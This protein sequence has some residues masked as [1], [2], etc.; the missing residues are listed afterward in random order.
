MDDDRDGHVEIQETKEFMA[1]ELQYKTSTQEKEEKFHGTDTDI[2]V[3]ELWKA[4][5]YSEVYNWTTDNLVVWINDH[6][7]LPQYADY[8]RRNRIDGQFLPR[9][10]LNENNYY[11]NVMQIKD[12]RHKRL[13]MIKATDLVLFGYHQ[14]TLV[15]FSFVWLVIYK[16]YLLI[17]FKILFK[18]PHNLIKDVLMISSLTLSIFVCIYLYSKHRQSLEQIKQMINDFEKLAEL[19]VINKLHSSQQLQNQ[20]NNDSWDLSSNLFQK[21]NST[22]EIFN[23]NFL[24]S[25][26]KENKLMSEKNSKLSLELNLAKKE[27]EQLK[28]ERESTVGQL[29]QLEL[30]LRE[31]E[32]VRAALRQTETKLEIIK[33]QAPSLLFNML[34]RSFESEK[35]LFDYKHKIIEKEKSLCSNEL[36][37]L[38][39]RQTGVFGAFKLVHSSYIEELNHR[40]DLIKY[41]NC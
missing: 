1:E 3:E 36:N 24:R 39:K 15:F 19:D 22:G 25:Q 17:A 16:N 21:R 10:A 29:K 40:I 2:S 5:K 30:A 18:E 14:S 34:K 28:R 6:V 27:A 20:Q 8:F 26:Q 38:S 31:L 11:A 23:F 4:W 32:K 13:I 41:L 9:L 33:F 35:E 37:K 7:K 12:S